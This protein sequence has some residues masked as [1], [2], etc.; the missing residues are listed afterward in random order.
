MKDGA[1][2]GIEAGHELMTKHDSFVD[3]SNDSRPTRVRSSRDLIDRWAMVFIVSLV[4]RVLLAAVIL[5]AADSMNALTAVPLAA[6]HAYFYLPYF[7]IVQ[8]ILGASATLVNHAHFV[9][10]GLTVKLIPCVVDSLLSVWFLQNNRF[11]QRYRRSSAWLYAFCPL[12]LILICLQ[13]Q[14]DSL[15][16]LPAVTALAMADLLANAT[17]ARRSTLL[18]IGALLGLAVLSKPAAFIVGGLVLPSFRYRESLRSWIQDASLI[19]IGATFTVVVFFLKFA[20]NGVHIHQ[21]VAN[22]FSYAGQPG[23]TL[24][25]PADLSIFSHFVTAQTNVALDFRQL[26]I[27]YVIGIALYQLV[28]RHPADRMAAAAAALLICPAIGGMAPQYLFWPFVFILASGRVRFASVYAIAS[29]FLYFLFFLLPGA[30]YT[31]GENLGALLPL[32]SLRFLGLPLAALKW[33]TKP[34]MLQVWHPITNLVVPLAMCVVGVYLLTS[35]RTVRRVS[36]EAVEPLELRS[37]RSIVPYTLLMLSVVFVYG[38][39][40]THMERATISAIYHGINRYAFAHPIYSWRHWKLHYFWATTPPYPSL[41]SG[42]WWGTIIILGPL[43]IAVWSAF[44]L[45]ATSRSAPH[46]GRLPPGQSSELS[47]RRRRFRLSL[48]EDAVKH[49]ELAHPKD[50]VGREIGRD[51][52]GAANIL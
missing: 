14:W 2:A 42:S 50:S 20:A 16:V 17:R 41:V 38:M 33:L 48:K 24:F 46:R 22:T 1:V 39:V 43:G 28:A 27:I 30:S 36:R 40:S 8:N 52:D 49:D 35:R 10:I 47:V 7:P 12:P 3:T 37:I 34:V 13:G 5:G 4:V 29:S 11:D 15:W 25:G 23:A 44:A 19:V 9:P 32:R 26:S 45:R 6:T 51:E 31:A 18:V 21:D